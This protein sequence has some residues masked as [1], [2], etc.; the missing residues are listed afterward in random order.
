MKDKRI[1]NS[2]AM[3]LSHSFHFSACPRGEPFMMCLTNP[4]EGAMCP[5]NPKAKCRP[6]SCGRCSAQFFDSEN[7]MVNC[8]AS[9]NFLISLRGR[10]DEF[11]AN[12]HSIYKQCW[13]N[14]GC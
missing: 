14:I 6:A 1:V 13:P 9:K 7:N 5:A 2:K 4:C 8:S 3:W 12:R 10:G 11:F